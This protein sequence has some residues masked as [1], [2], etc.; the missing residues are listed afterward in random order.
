MLSVPP[1]NHL[2]KGRSHSRVLSNG[3]VQSTRSR[4][5]RAQNASKS[6]SASSYRLAFALAC[7]VNAGS[8]GNV[9]RSASR[10]SIAACDGEDDSTVTARHLL[11]SYRRSAILRVRPPPPDRVAG[12]CGAA[13]DRRFAALRRDCRG[14]PGSIEPRS[15]ARRTAEIEGARPKFPNIRPSNGVTVASGKRR[16]STPAAPAIHTGTK[17]AREKYRIAGHPCPTGCT[18]LRRYD[19]AW[20]YRAETGPLNGGRPRDGP[21]LRRDRRVRPGA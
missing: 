8:G 4:A 19:R 13:T 21:A 20:R 2:A 1:T 7:A 9:R 3:F 12:T 6:R 11:P 14:R 5:M 16:E 17:V 18:G 10:F 15:R